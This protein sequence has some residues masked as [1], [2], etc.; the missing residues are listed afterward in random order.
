MGGNAFNAILQSAA[1]PRLPPVVYHALKARLQPK[2]EQLYHLVT[3][4]VEAPEKTDYGDLDFLV[5]GAKLDAIGDENDAM[6]DGR[7]N[8]SHERVL[9]CIGAKYMNPMDGN[10]T[11]NFAVPVS[12]GEWDNLGHGKDELERRKVTEDGEI[13]YQVDVHVCTNKP[14]WERIRLF[15]SYGD[16]G[17]ILGLL[18]RNTGMKLGEKG[19]E[20]PIPNHPPFKLSDS[21]DEILPFLGLSKA[22]HEEGFQTK[23]EIFEWVSKLKYFD[24]STF[25]SEGPGITK[26]KAER[27]MY[28][29]FVDWVKEKQLAM[30]VS[31]PTEGSSHSERRQQMKDDALAFFHKQEDYDTRMRELSQF[32]TAQSVRARLKERFTGNT[33]QEWIGLPGHWRRTKQIMDA[34]RLQVGGEEGILDILEQDG[35]DELKKLVLE[36][37]GALP[38]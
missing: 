9:E 33:I 23:R 18:V 7:I 14:E 22:D 34:L 20:M 17:M 16:F 29:Q 25:R 28:A 31:T 21:F 3:V 2:I 35:E 1:F 4:P 27:K 15:H 8:V 32:A 12:K 19:L 38:S 6:T 30:G 36:I 37:Q 26:V 24:L 5:V 13:Y 10:R 11:S